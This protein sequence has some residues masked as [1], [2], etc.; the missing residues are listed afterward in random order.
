MDSRHHRPQGSSQLLLTWARL[1]PFNLF[2]PR[3]AVGSGLLSVVFFFGILWLL[4]P[5][6]PAFA[7]QRLQEFHIDAGDATLTLNEFSRQ[8][9]LQLLFDYNIVRGKRTQAIEGEF[10]FSFK[11]AKHK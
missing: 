10:D 7:G 1:P 5:A 9:S 2:S 4:L 11:K 6:R 3:R 8:S